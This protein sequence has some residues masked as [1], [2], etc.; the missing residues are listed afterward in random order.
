[1]AQQL[2]R[3]FNHKPAM[4]E[5]YRWLSDDLK[6]RFR[7]TSALTRDFDAVVK[8]RVRSIKRSVKQTEVGIFKSELQLR[9]HFGGAEHEEAKRQA[10]CYIAMC[11]EYKVTWCLQ[12]K[13]CVFPFV[14]CFPFYQRASARTCSRSTISG[15][16][17]RRTCWWKN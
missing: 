9:V 2:N 11:K 16:R 15:P 5:I 10:S 3:A 7:M 6:R 14:V 17:Q 4:K 13:T 1:M 8:S 12:C